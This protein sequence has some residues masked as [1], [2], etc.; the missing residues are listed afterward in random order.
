[1]VESLQSVMDVVSSVISNVGFPI[2]CVVAMFYQMEREREAHREE[3][4][5]WVEALNNNTA[6]MQSFIDSHRKE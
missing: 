6:V 4:E 2:A 5:K 1:M 3:S